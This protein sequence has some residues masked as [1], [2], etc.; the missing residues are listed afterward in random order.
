MGG[1]K[2]SLEDTKPQVKRLITKV[3]KKN[4]ED[5]L[6]KMYSKPSVPFS[7]KAA[8]TKIPCITFQGAME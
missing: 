8:V 7:S 1:G 4:L 5:G 3:T 2:I 6:R